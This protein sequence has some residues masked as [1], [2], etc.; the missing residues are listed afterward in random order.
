MVI[1]RHFIMTKVCVSKK[2]GLEGHVTYM[3]KNNS[4][5]ITHRRPKFSVAEA[6]QH[7]DPLGELGLDTGPM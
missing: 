5:P 7:S 1:S 3:A 4:R 2:P 6:W